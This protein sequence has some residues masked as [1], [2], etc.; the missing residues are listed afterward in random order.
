MELLFDAGADINILD[1]DKNSPLHV[2]CYGEHKESTQIACIK[3]L[4]EKRISLV[5]RNKRELMPIHCCAMQGRIDGIQTLLDA[6]TDNHIRQKLEKE[7]ELPPSLAHLAVAN[8]H[9]ETAH[10]FVKCSNFI[11]IRRYV[12]YAYTY[13]SNGR[14]GRQNK[15]QNLATVVSRF[16]EFD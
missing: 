14:T 9:F 11:L 10:W 5:S 3:K 15:R 7:N 16:L 13:Y 2:K 4:I 6:D 12:A 1:E 8:D